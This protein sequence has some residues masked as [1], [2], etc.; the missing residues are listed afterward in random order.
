MTVKPLCRERWTSDE[1][2]AVEEDEEERA[3]SQKA[4]RMN[5]ISVWN[6]VASHKYVCR[7]AC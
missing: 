6:E 3:R 2:D 4:W 1:E 7:A 5:L